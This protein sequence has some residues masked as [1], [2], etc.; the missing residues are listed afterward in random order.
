LTPGCSARRREDVLG[1]WRKILASM[2]GGGGIPDLAGEE[3]VTRGIMRIDGTDTDGELTS[4]KG[5]V[6]VH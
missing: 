3:A 4:G 2:L 5:I 1:S 6:L